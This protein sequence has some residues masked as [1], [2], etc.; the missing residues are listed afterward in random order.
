MRVRCKTN[1]IDDSFAQDT[2][3]R[4]KRYISIGDS[5]L[6]IEIGK[7][8][9]V[10]GIE[11]WDNYPWLYICADPYDEYP[12]PVALDFFEITEKNLFTLDPKVKRHIQ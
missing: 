11:F 12:K 6:D 8:Y 5:E 10:Y 9:T 3:T 7:E 4:L 1:K 2:A